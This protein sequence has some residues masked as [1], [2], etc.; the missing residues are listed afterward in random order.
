V[1]ASRHVSGCNAEVPFCARG[2]GGMGAGADVADLD[3]R[4]VSR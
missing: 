3:E 2:V 1:N 4:R